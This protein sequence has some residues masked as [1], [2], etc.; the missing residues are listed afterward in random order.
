MTGPYRPRRFL[1]GIFGA[2]V[3]YDVTLPPAYQALA[4]EGNG[5]VAGYTNVFDFNLIN[6]NWVTWHD[7]EWQNWIQVDALLNT[8]IGFL[9]IKGI[10]RPLTTYTAGD[11]VYDPTDTS[12][13]YRANDAHTSST[14]FATDIAAGHWTLVTEL[15]PPVE[16]VFGRTG[17]VIAAAGDYAAF[18]PSIASVDAKNAT[19]DTAITN[20]ASAAAAANTNANNR[21]LK[22]GDTMTGPL[23]LPAAA[24]TLN[25]HAANKAYVDSVAGAAGGPFLPLT[26]GTL[27]GGLTIDLTVSNPTGSTYPFAVRG[28]SGQAV[29]ALRL[30]NADASLE[31]L[32]L[33]STA[34]NDVVL[35]NRANTAST[36]SYLQLNADGS[37]LL[38]APAGWTMPGPLAL[39]GAVPV[40]EFDSTAAAS[41]A[42]HYRF[43]NDGATF[44]LQA[45][46]TANF[47]TVDPIWQIRTVVS[48]GTDTFNIYKGV[49][50]GGE[51]G[52]T[53]VNL[54]LDSTYPSIW[55]ADSTPAGSYPNLLLTVGNSNF[56][57]SQG[58]ANGAVVATFLWASPIEVQTVPLTKLAAGHGTVE[59]GMATT[60]QI[61][62]QRTSSYNY[63][64]VPDGAIMRVNN[65]SGVAWATVSSAS[66]WAAGTSDAR[67]KENVADIH[68]GLDTIMA[69]RPVEFDWIA[70]QRHDIGFIAQ[71]VEPLIPEIVEIWPADPDIEGDLDTYAMRKDAVVAVLVRA[72][73]EQQEQI[74]ALTER[75]TSLERTA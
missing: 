63:L 56:R 30:L 29:Y 51:I 14:D 25:A 50:I 1:P 74:I 48:G 10:W 4:D 71:E 13:F 72:V 32:A 49:S 66:G 2:D 46:K 19:Q 7:Y 28:N 24:P 54:K 5:P 59:V 44:M 33:Y 57:F 35:R 38:S 58:D 27:N 42:G 52:G 67:L 8:A 62:F 73:Q 39:G 17:N 20:A 31:R 11:G 34:A 41:P 55:F 61:K 6:F 12:K 22:A 23:V 47:A 60:S 15:G 64:Q 68:Y 45:A 53:T 3:P 9:N 26:G 43:V 75:I 16:S 69:L 40:L 21:V 36:V 65:A 37:G 18:Y 70:E